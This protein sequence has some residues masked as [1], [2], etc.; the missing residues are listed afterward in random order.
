MK[1][2][3]VLMTMML[4]MLIG[5]DQITGDVGTDENKTNQENN[6][7][8]KDESNN[9]GEQNQENN[10]NNNANQN[11]ENEN[12]GNNDKSTFKITYEL[13]GGVNDSE[14]PISFTK[15][16]PLYLKAA[17]KDGYIF[18]G[19][20]V[21]TDFSGNRIDYLPF[22]DE[23]FNVILRDITLYAKWNK[24]VTT[25]EVITSEVAQ[26]IS[27]LSAG[28][29]KLVVTGVLDSSIIEN[30]KNAMCDKQDILIALDLNK[31]TGLTSVG[32]MAFLGCT[33]LINVIIPDSVT[34]IEEYAFG[35]CLNL[36]NIT[37]PNSVTSIGRCAFA[38][39]QNLVNVTIPNS[40]T[41]IGD[42]A[43]SCKSLTKFEIDTD[44]KNYSIS[45]DGKILYNKDK[46]VLIA[47]PSASGDFVIPN[48]VVSISNYAFY[49]TDLTSVTIPN[50]VTSIGDGAF[51]SCVNLEK[52]II[53]DS[54]TSI[55]NLTFNGCIS[56]INI[57]IPD[58]VTSIGDGAF[59]GCTNLVSVTLSDN[60]VSIGNAV[61]SLCSSLRNV[62]IPDNVISIG[63][64]AFSGC[65]NLII[66]V[67]ENNKNYMVSEG[68]LY[69]KDISTLMFA[70]K[71][72][73]TITIP[74]FITS[75][76]DSALSNC[77]DLTTVT[78]PNSVT[79]IGISTFFGCDNLKTVNYKGTPEQWEEIDI[80]VNNE[81]LTG[82]NINYN[83]TGE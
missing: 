40:V 43:F 33:N 12:N 62:I 46:T 50:N 8:N 70:E 29:Y 23:N 56:L 11:G 17:T 36:A 81:K 64:S 68:C 18:G 71:N 69:A 58:T 53:S 27:E 6:S 61:F 34:S 25:I 4:V 20:Y 65:T 72:V 75:I 79:K 83:Y 7:S 74:D 37:I 9:T 24:E 15:K 38:G 77:S 78:I 32:N 16:E 67:S 13:N 10:E 28:T 51:A 49:I 19:W 5:C 1:R 45:E 73:T 48:N 35:S 22:C 76:A 26:K 57:T 60:M 41:S 31:T 44:N 54:I 21:T 3:L 14:N 59:M 82:A 66:K 52:I 47:Y 55:G 42:G 80:N 39:C 63:D 30:I 2:F